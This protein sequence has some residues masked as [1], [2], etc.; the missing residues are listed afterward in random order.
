MDQAGTNSFKQK[1]LKFILNSFV[2]FQGV[3]LSNIVDAKQTVDQILDEFIEIK[4]EEEEDDEFLSFSTNFHLSPQKEDDL[5]RILEASPKKS[6]KIQQSSQ[7][8]A[9]KEEKSKMIV[10]WPLAKKLHQIEEI[11]SN[12]ESTTTQ[13]DK[14]NVKRKKMIYEEEIYKNLKEDDL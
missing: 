4:D 12:Q 14:T 3:I 6:L 5:E 1:N 7:D 10:N 9:K 2:K 11:E 8:D 13:N